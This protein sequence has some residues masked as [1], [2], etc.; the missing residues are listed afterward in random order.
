MASIDFFDSVAFEPDSVVHP[1]TCFVYKVASRCNLDCTYCYEYNM[2]DTSWREQ[3]HFTSLQT[4]EQLAV[5]V[6]EHAVRHNLDYVTFSFH[7]GEPLLIG[8]TFFA[9]AVSTIR[10]TLGPTVG[11]SFGIQTNGTLLTEDVVTLFRDHDI[12]IGL[13]LD[14]PQ[15]VHDR[16]RIYA[17]GKGSFADVMRGVR[18]LQSPAGS[19]VFRGILAVIEVTADPLAVFDFLAELNPPAI[20]FL[21]PHGNWQSL[22]PGKR[23][24][25][26]QTI[27]AQWLKTIFDAWFDGRHSHI[28]IR[29]FEEIIEYE[30][31]GHGI[32]ETLG[33]APVDLICIAADGSIEAVDTMKSVFPRAHKLGLN[34]FDHSFD[35]ALSHPHVRARQIGMRALSPTCMHCPIV[36][37]CGGGYFPHR[38]SQ[39]SNFKNPS[40]YCA[41]LYELITHIQKRVSNARSIQ[42]QLQR[43]VAHGAAC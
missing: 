15:L 22:P 29:T 2:G 34:V 36:E 10:S 24:H 8:P 33:L 9:E 40:V 6:R 3:P 37:T 35:E 27:Y 26:D 43:P 42:P 41:D 14:G 32:L 23:G 17:T 18:W 11:C 7:G 28:R 16:H 20:D 30:L 5:R 12:G 25:L 39:A 1:L 19:A 13:S 4:V 21:L 38:Y 31:G